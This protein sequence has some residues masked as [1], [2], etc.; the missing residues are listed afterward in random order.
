M[1]TLPVPKANAAKAKYKG[2]SLTGP[3]SLRHTKRTFKR[4][5]K[6]TIASGQFDPKRPIIVPIK[7][8]RRYRSF[9][10]D[11]TRFSALIPETC[12]MDA[13]LKARGVDKAAHEGALAA[14]GLLNHDGKIANK[15]K[16]SANASEKPNMPTI[17]RSVSPVEV[18][19][20]RRGG[21][22][23]GQPEGAQI[24]QIHRSTP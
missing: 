9:V 3:E 11:K 7:E 16:G 23:K 15:V 6:R 8:D 14:G 12:D 4:A 13:Q 5:L 17:G 22:A 21:Q 20:G 10:V 24:R 1:T 19:M 2:I 18:E